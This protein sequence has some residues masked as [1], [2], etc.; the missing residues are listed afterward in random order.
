MSL[1]DNSKRLH[2][3]ISSPNANFWER[4][5]FKFVE[6]LALRADVTVCPKP[7]IAV[8]TPRVEV[9]AV[10]PLGVPSGQNYAEAATQSPVARY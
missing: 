3:Q 9:L 8:V 1:L 10:E 6:T 2:G 4:S 7:Q 5:H